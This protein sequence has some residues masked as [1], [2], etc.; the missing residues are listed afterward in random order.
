GNNHASKSSPDDFEV[1][2]S[3]E[4]EED[5]DKGTDFI[6]PVTAD[7]VKPLHQDRMD[8]EALS[9]PSSLPMDATPHH[10]QEGSEKRSTSIT[11]YP[12]S[13]TSYP[14][15]MTSCHEDTEV[16]TGETGLGQSYVED[17]PTVT[18]PETISYPTRDDLVSRCHH[19]V[20]DLNPNVM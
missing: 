8:R 16:R 3:S 20:D 9:N 4:A 2:V 10:Q 18:P 5:Y 17:F 14:A 1:D 11:S 13:M 15:L 7:I 6:M 19:D 12:A